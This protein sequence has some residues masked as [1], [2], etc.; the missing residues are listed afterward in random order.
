MT[1]VI[2]KYSYSCMNVPGSEQILMEL[3][4]LNQKKKKKVLL[5]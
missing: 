3:K 4:A 2:I 1:F 5:P